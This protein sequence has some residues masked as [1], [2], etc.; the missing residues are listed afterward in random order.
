MVLCFYPLGGGN[1]L[2]QALQIRPLILYH[3]LPS[4]NCCVL[5]RCCRDFMTLTQSKEAMHLSLHGWRDVGKVAYR[6]YISHAFHLPEKIDE[7]IRSDR[8]DKSKTNANMLN[9]KKTSFIGRC[10]HLNPQPILFFEFVSA[11]TDDTSAL[12]FVHNWVER[13]HHDTL[14]LHHV[15]PFKIISFHHQNAILIIEQQIIWL[16]LNQAQSHSSSI[17]REASWGDVGT[18]PGWLPKEV[19]WP[20][21]TRLPLDT[22]RASWIEYTSWLKEV[23]A[24]WLTL[25]PLWPE[26]GRVEVSGRMDG[27]FYWSHSSFV[28]G[29]L[30]YLMSILRFNNN[31]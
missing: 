4:N 7:M 5:L 1:A 28:Y 30:G 13:S 25:L 29:K 8:K 15:L 21:P 2:Q 18:Y 14:G 12:L 11:F 27:W 9:L 20:C 17:L 23:W 19:F 22:T 16:Y 6:A 31:D 3:L 26:L 10:Y 24:C